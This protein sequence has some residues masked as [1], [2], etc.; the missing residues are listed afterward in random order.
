LDVAV[1]GGR[2]SV[3][4]EPLSGNGAGLASESAGASEVW[5]RALSCSQKL[6]DTNPTANT[7]AF[8][9]RILQIAS[10]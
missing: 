10:I 2:S 6:S 4:V 7:A 5:H 1:D 3:A 8:F 9:F